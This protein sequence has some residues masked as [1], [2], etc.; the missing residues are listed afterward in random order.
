[1]ALY[2][3]S[4]TALLT[5]FLLI[6][7]TIRVDISLRYQSD[8]LP[9]SPNRGVSLPVTATCLNAQPGVCC[10]FSYVG[11][12]YAYFEHLTAFDIAA[13]WRYRITNPSDFATSPLVSACSGRVLESRPGPGDWEWTSEDMEAVSRSSGASY[14]TMP[15]SL[16]PGEEAKGWMLMEGLL[17]LAWGGGK[18]FASPAAERLFGG[19]GSRLRP[20]TRTG[21]QIIRSAQTGTVHARSPLSMVFPDRVEWNGTTFTKHGMASMMYTDKTGQVVNL[22]TLFAENLI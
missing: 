12:T 5:I 16:P 13:V 14:I 19:G 3:I 4:Q 20:R 21:R 10:I 2:K 6:R 9:N 8:P 17:G 15:R 18:W 7:H 1:M 11:A 22:T